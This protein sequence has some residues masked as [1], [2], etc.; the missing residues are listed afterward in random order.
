MV[1]EVVDPCMNGSFSEKELLKCVHIGLL[2]VQGNPA[3]RPTMSAV[4]M[5]LGSE[6]FT[7]HVP[8]KPS[9][10]SRMNGAKAE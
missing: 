5:M 7:V 4:V 10:G 3:D 1:L 2:C 8:S 9:L 6:T